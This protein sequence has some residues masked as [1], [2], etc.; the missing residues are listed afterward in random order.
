MR[1]SDEVISLEAERAA[2]GRAHH[3]AASMLQRLGR[4]ESRGSSGDVFTDEYIANVVRGAVRKLQQ[5][6]VVFGRIDDEHAWRV[7]L[8][9]IDDGGDRLVIDWRAPFAARFYQ[10]SFA[11]PL[12]LERRVSY[13]G[14]IEDLL[15]EEFTTG[16]VSGTSPLLAELSRDRGFT[17]RAAVST[18]QSEQDSLVRLDPQAKLVLRGGPGTG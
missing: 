11:D 14:S 3:A 17:M 6:L 10:A 15:I 8:Y 5:D 1:P 9:G 7:G 16:L 13:V 18:L 12:G 4:I 2:L